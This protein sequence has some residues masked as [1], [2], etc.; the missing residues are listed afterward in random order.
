MHS[1]SHAE[2]STPSTP[3]S[4][5]PESLPVVVIPAEGFSSM[6][7]AA[8]FYRDRFG[9]RPHTLHGPQDRNVS[10]RERG[11]KPLWEG[12]RTITPEDVVDDA[13]RAVF[14]GSSKTNLGIILQNFH[15][16]VDIDSKKDEGESARRW[17]LEQPHLVGYPR[18]DTANGAHQHFFCPD[19]PPITKAG[20]PY[21]SPLVNTVAEG[22]DVELFFRGLSVV[23][24]P[25]VHQTDR[26]YTWA[27][28]G[29]IPVVTWAQLKAWFGFTLPDE[30]TRQKIK[31][32]GGERWWRRY[33]GNLKT[34][35]L[36]ALCD[37]LGV[38]G[39]VLKVDDGKRAVRC[40]WRHEHSDAGDPWQ[41]S[42]S[43]TAILV[44]AA[45]N[46]FP[47]FKC[48]HA[49]CAGRELRELLDWAEQQKPG[50]VDRHC[51]ATRTWTPGKLGRD[52]RP[53][54]PAPGPGQPICEFA[55]EVGKVLAGTE[56]W[57]R[58]GQ[59]VVMI[60][61][62]PTGWGV[63]TLVLHPMSAA[64]VCSAIEDHVEVGNLTKPDDAG[65]SEFIP[66]SLNKAQADLLLAAAR[67]RDEL[68]VIERVLDVPVPVLVDGKLVLPQHAYDA[69][70]KTY[71]NPDAPKIQPMRVETAKQL[72][73]E[74]FQEFCWADSQSLTH[75][76]ARL[77]TTGCRGI[78][79]WGA[80]TP[81]WLFMANRERSGKD[82]AA[83]IAPLLYEGRAVEEA[84]L[85]PR[86]STETRKRI[87][88][89]LLAG[90]R[91]LHFANCRGHLDDPALEEAITARMLGDRIL[92]RSENVCL[93]NEIEFSLSANTGITFKAD[94]AQRARTIRLFLS[95][96]NPNRRRFARPELHA[97]VVHRRA[98]L[99]SAVYSLIEH[100]HKQ[101]MPAGPTP[102]ASFPE[103]SR[104]VGGV[105]MAAGLGDPCVPENN[106]AHVGGDEETENMKVLYQ[107]GH[108]RWGAKR[109]EP[110]QIFE[111]LGGEDVPPLFSWLDLAER[112]GQTKLGIM[113]RRFVGRSLGTIILRLHD[114]KLRRP[115]YSFELCQSGDE[116]RGRSALAEIFGSPAQPATPDGDVGD[117]GNLDK[118]PAMGSSSSTLAPVQDHTLSPVNGVSQVANVANVAIPTSPVPIPITDR[119]TLEGLARAIT[120]STQPVA[121]D[122][123]THGKG[124]DAL[125]PWRGEV[126]L[127]TL[128]LPNTPPWILDLKG[129]GYDL[130]PLRPALEAKQIIG[131]NLKFDALWLRQRCGITLR[132]LACT[133][134]ASR[135]LSAGTKEPNDLGACLSR[136]LDL[137]IPKD[138]GQ[139]D[140]G[141]AQL[142]PE[143][144]RYAAQD[145]AHL[146]ALHAGLLR[147]LE[148]AG[149]AAVWQLESDLIPVVVA[150]EHH[151]FLVDRAVLAQL[152]TEAQAVVDSTT[153]ALKSELGSD[154]NPGS[155]AQVKRALSARGVE[156]AST[157]EETLTELTDPLASKLLQFRQAKHQL[158]QVES[159]VDAIE[160]DGRIHASF[161][162]TGTDTGRFSCS[163][164]NLQNV[165]RGPLRS[166]FIAPPEN[167]LI[168]ADYS[169]IE[170]R[171]GTVVADET[172][173]LDAFRAGDDLH[174]QTAALVLGKSAASVTK[175][176]RQLAKAVN[177]GLL[178]GQG[179]AGLVRYAKA[180]YGV[181][182]NEAQAQE[183]RAR[184][185]N[186]YPG[187]AKWH[188]SA[189]SL[190]TQNVREARTTLGR[191]RFL[192]SGRENWWQRFT[193]LLNSP[194]QGGS[195]D[196]MKRALV[197][198]ALQLPPG[199][200]IVSTVHDEI[201]VE[202][203]DSLADTVKEILQRIMIEQMAGLYPSVPIEVE[204]SV[205]QNWGEK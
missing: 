39:D 151:G 174:R 114:E 91:A 93:P 19:L 86:N 139:S 158:K 200:A 40:P 112:P 118:P 178:Y 110:K 79:G 168:P 136:H 3:P 30:D 143:Q 157:N 81:F 98:D 145:V 38:L 66:N 31:G 180:G 154:F 100:W 169:Q 97:W 147:E 36:T 126:R 52:Q 120:E 155:P 117:L 50:I 140:W 123:E 72:I 199:A 188:A 107:M 173:M 125:N 159:L 197:S 186:A 41:R 184:F 89:A 167:S 194:V 124:Q 175:D 129:I 189:K 74:I 84:P 131:H 8:R 71:L 22:V 102:F 115:K 14:H 196:G 55:A 160:S 63:S 44:N 33:S 105:M 35:N 16:V 78:M 85:E 205:C 87:T 148:S 13:L 76:I 62:E 4:N 103:W 67:L 137:D 187:L 61:S 146:H 204:A 106:A 60:R 104:V 202:A 11:K 179:A 29:Q 198:I 9:S 26:P 73:Q 54:I 162:P 113:L 134:T 144:L 177:F 90:R 23:V 70:F 130:G 116:G 75:A 128:A 49:H 20:K 182:L 192:P 152:Q 171:V 165:C 132:Q 96:E 161:K 127:L 58:H 95:D 51:A 195:A 6:F 48:L 164:P 172:K 141:R 94:L 92:G 122:V 185:F 176:D 47:G 15:V 99:L 43:S 53:Q 193:G 163:N 28:T 21:G 27:V 183:I 135:L 18:E 46:R 203:P 17:V 25:S 142:T 57:F 201:I 88:A 2:S 156:V 166:A 111:M 80:K 24:A 191:R 64:A 56:H 150:M 109:V 108:E 59:H 32:K 149:L 170:L 190:A 69:R 5:P 45:T 37:E 119:A 68:P 138:Q 10:E 133:M 1:N 153:A 65:T 82:Y 181:S 42:D 121:L 83:G 77:I 101:G 34:L 12:Y 7:D